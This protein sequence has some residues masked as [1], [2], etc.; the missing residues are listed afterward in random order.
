MSLTSKAPGAPLSPRERDIVQLASGG[1]CDAEIADD[2]KISV[3]TV[4][5]YWRY[6]IRPVL[7]AENRTHAVALA[8]AQGL[9]SPQV[10]A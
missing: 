6:R 2:L 9:A 3:H 7:G 8:V 5:E 4:C 10:T 1:Y